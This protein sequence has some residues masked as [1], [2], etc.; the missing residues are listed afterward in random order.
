MRVVVDLR[1][2]L[3]GKTRQAAWD[4]SIENLLPRA[5]TDI[6]FNLNHY[7]VS[8][9]PFV[10]RHDHQSPATA[11]SIDYIIMK[12]A[13]VLDLESH[14]ASGHGTA[15]RNADDSLIERV[16]SRLDPLFDAYGWAD[17]EFAWTNETSVFGGTIMCSFASPNLSFWALLKLPEGRTRARPLPL[18]DR[19]IALNKS[20]Y[21]VIFETNEGDTPRILVSAMASAWAR[22]ERGSLPVAWAIDP[23]LAERFPA[24]FDYF[25]ATATAN[26][27]FIAGTAGAGY[28]FLNQMSAQQLQVYGERVG[29]LTARYGPHVFD[30]YGYANLSVHEHYERAAR[31]GG[32]GPT[33]FVTQPNWVNGA[34][35]APYDPFHCPEDNLALNTT[36]TPLICSSGRPRLFYYSGSLNPLCPSCTLAERIRTAATR[37]PPPFFVLVYGGL[38]AFGG[39]EKK[40]PRNFF[41]LQTD[42][43]RRLGEG[44]EVIGASE[45]ARLAREALAPTPSHR[46]D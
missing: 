40:S 45:M 25:A 3:A 33:A 35:V 17:D 19:G 9:D 20:K 10:D 26:D 23:L 22:P 37:H 30:T 15:P 11:S 2:V 6:V 13:F 24:L 42:A 46:V 7:R 14:A 29:A 32:A 28:A 36:G 5:A 8:L 16:F 4:W 43:M 1:K 31:E 41:T 21:Y 39:S 27:S 38:Q 44:F 12:N 18:N 34:T